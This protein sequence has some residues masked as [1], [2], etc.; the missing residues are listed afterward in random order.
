MYPRPLWEQ[1]GFSYVLL[2]DTHI[3]VP[4]ERSSQV[5]QLS[6]YLMFSVGPPVL[7]YLSCLCNE[8]MHF[9]PIMIIVYILPD[10]NYHAKGLNSVAP[11][12][13]SLDFFFPQRDA[14]NSALSK[15][16]NLSCY[17]RILFIEIRC[18]LDS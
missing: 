16:E 7:S 18:F 6:S 17:H 8:T 14:S 10:W 12:H 11:F 9:F 5:S 3:S 15:P 13:W 2:D 4:R 1:M